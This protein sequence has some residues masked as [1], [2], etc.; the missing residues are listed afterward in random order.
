MTGKQEKA[1]SDSM[2]SKGQRLPYYP[3]FRYEHLKGLMERLLA[4]IVVLI[5]L[6]IFALIAICVVV[7]SPGG[8]IFRQE[9]VGKDGRKFMMYKFRSMRGTT[10]DD[11]YRELLRRLVMEGK[12]HMVYKAEFQPRVTR[13]GSFLRKTNLDELPQLF[14]I[15]KGDLG[16]VGPRPDL[17]YSVECYED[18]M[19]RRLVVKPG[20]TGL[21]QVSGGNWLTFEEMVRFDIDYIERQS[22]LLDCKILLQTAGIVLGRD[23]SYQE[24]QEVR[25]G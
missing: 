14:N 6:P 18:W 23:G 7:D 1:R 9:R 2:R 3:K 11:D 25:D 13:V 10:D 21:W 20:M 5:L 8:A 16:L 4:L 24:Q 19:K 22:P 12:P 15:L 17:P